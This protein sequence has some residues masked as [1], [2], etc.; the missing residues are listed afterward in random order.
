MEKDVVCLC[1]A[2]PVKAHAVPLVFLASRGIHA[3]GS[4]YALPNALD[5]RRRS[6]SVRYVTSTAR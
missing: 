5:S 2:G 3:F 4:A 1:G 6:S